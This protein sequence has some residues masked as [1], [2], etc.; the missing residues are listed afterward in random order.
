MI[1]LGSQHL[2]AYD[3]DAVVVDTIV[4][5]GRPELPTVTG[6]FRILA[7]YS[8]YEFISPWPRGSPY[9]YAPVWSTYA[10]EF[11][12]SGFFIHDAPW[13]SVW[14]PGANV[15]AGSHGCVNVPIAPMARLYA[16]ARVGDAVVV[17]P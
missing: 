12:S 8:P 7:K 4:A 14:G 3:G 15:T 5:T 6:T 2:W 9:W 10:M 13:R 16:W 11:E 1:S 17:E